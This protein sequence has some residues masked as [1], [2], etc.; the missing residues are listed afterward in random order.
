MCDLSDSLN[1]ARK[2]QN[3]AFPDFLTMS[4]M[5]LPELFLSHWNSAEKSCWLWLLLVATNRAAKLHAS[6]VSSPLQ[7]QWEQEER[8]KYWPSEESLHGLENIWIFLFHIE[9][10]R[11]V[12]HYKQHCDLAPAKHKEVAMLLVTD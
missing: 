3:G 12:K 1:C 4:K 5:Q 7:A 8:S 6:W 9:G 11:G 10:F 2:S